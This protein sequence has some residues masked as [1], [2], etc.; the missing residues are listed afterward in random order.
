MEQTRSRTGV[1]I[2]KNCV[3]WAGRGEKYASDEGIVLFFVFI[4]VAGEHECSR[5]CSRCCSRCLRVNFLLFCSDPEA[6]FSL[7]SDGIL[8]SRLQG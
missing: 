5:S 8:G 3:V 2:L 6:S 7:G 4:G 1:A